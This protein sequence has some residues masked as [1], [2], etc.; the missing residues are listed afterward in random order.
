MPTTLVQGLRFY[1][2][3]WIHEQG[4]C[5]DLDNSQLKKAKLKIESLPD[6]INLMN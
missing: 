4:K 6:L 1:E 2:P 3:N 5:V